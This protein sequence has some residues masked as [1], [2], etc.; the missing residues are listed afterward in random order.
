MSAETSRGRAMDKYA[1]KSR[2][3]MI[4]IPDTD[5]ERLDLVAREM[6]RSPDRRGAMRV[7]T[8]SRLAN[9][10]VEEYLGR[11]K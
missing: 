6:Q 5:Y 7:W 10:A 2:T 11:L 9:L 8:V 4:T 3:I 1:Q